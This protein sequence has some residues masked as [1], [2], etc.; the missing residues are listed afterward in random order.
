MLSRHRNLSSNHTASRTTRPFGIVLLA[1]AL[2][3]ALP[4]PGAAQAVSPSFDDLRTEAHRGESVYVIDRAGVKVKGRVLRIAPTS[5]ELLV[6]DASRKWPASDV[7][8]IT[9]RRG[10]AGRGALVGLAIG[11]GLGVVLVL[12]DSGCQPGFDDCGRRD[13]AD[14]LFLGSLFGGFGGGVGAALGAVL[15]PEHILYAAPTRPATHAL[16]RGGGRGVIG[17]HAQL[18]F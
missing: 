8:W 10:N 13:A 15:R 7:A 18:R 12:T 4:C 2:L 1:S 14:A 17:F 9:Q 5:I 3:A 11:A 6:H 16:N